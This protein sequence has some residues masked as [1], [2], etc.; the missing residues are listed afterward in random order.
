MIEIK[1]RNN[2]KIKN[3]YMIKR[4]LNRYQLKIEIK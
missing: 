3:K 1:I 2:M 4:K